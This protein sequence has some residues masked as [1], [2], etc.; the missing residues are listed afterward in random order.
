MYY[1]V[2]IDSLFL[3]SFTMNLYLLMLL[4]RSLHRTA[5]R[6]RLVLGA[7]AGGF[8]YCLA[9]ILPFGGAIVKTLVMAIVLNSAILYAVFRPASLKAFIKLLE[10]TLKY[11]LLLGGAF[12]LLIN[13]VKVFR[14]H[15]MQMMGVLAC[16][17][18]LY[19]II[20]CY[21]EKKE[22]E[23][24]GPCKVIL[25]SRAGRSVAVDGIVDTG[26]CLREPI[27]GEP[28]SVIDK[29]LFEELWN[30]EEEPVGFRAIPYRSVGCE[31]GIMMGYK[32]PEMLIRQ[33]GFE[34]IC[35]NVYVGLNEGKVA[36][37]GD[38]GM[39]LHPELLKK[40]ESTK[41][42]RAKHDIKGKYAGK[43]TV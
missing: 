32:I 16:G 14:E 8:G 11:C 15:R 7:A 20:S 9:F 39:L 24:A 37:M 30:G 18:L 27:S 5:T 28:V 43:N 13:H 1:E 25:K 29:A 19:L 40:R 26:N 41:N 35:R 4:N 12:F 31:R 17:G 38:Y 6:W 23:R 22:K 33:D 36:S 2:Y 10:H 34:W 42:R 21:E 3:L